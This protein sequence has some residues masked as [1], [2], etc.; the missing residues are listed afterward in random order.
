MLIEFAPKIKMAVLYMVDINALPTT[1][2]AFG[3]NLISIYKNLSFTIN[4]LNQTIFDN[5]K[6]PQ[7]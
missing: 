7:E 2:C 1:Y 6:R 5:C 3:G 4:G